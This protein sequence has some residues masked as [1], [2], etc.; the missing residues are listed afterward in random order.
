VR[1]RGVALRVLDASARKSVRR[2]AFGM[3]RDKNFD[4]HTRAR[5]RRAKFRV[6]ERV[7]GNATQNFVSQNAYAATPHEFY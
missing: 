7:L 5:R 6:A 4:S 1:L 3:C 2:F